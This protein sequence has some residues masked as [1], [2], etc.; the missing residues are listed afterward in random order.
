MKIT[1]NGTEYELAEKRS[2]SKRLELAKQA[3]IE[4]YNVDEKLGIVES[5]LNKEAIL[6][7]FLVPV[8]IPELAPEISEMEAN[9]VMDKY[10]GLYDLLRFGKHDGDEYGYGD[11]DEVINMMYDIAGKVRKNVEAEASLSYRLGQLL[12]GTFNI[13]ELMDTV[14]NA[15]DISNKML[16]AAQMFKD[17]EN[18]K[19]T[20]KA[21]NN[22]LNFAKK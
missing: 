8:Y 13:G 2:Y 7:K 19:P 18:V 21:G 16:T 5:W 17:S 11:F 4:C 10:E 9:D 6:T 14:V 3:F 15:D 20:K 1:Y 22:I 12:D